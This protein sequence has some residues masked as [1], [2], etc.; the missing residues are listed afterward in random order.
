MGVVAAAAPRQFYGIG[1][2]QARRPCEARLHRLC[3][4]HAETDKTQTA[5][6]HDIVSQCD[7]SPKEWEW[8]NYAARIAGE[9]YRAMYDHEAFC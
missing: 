4:R 1:L 8:M 7:L 3:L 5:E 6:I 2:R 9:F